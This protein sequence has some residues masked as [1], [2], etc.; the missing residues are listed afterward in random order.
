VSAVNEQLVSRLMRDKER[1]RVAVYAIAGHP[2]TP[3]RVREIAVSALN[4]LREAL[5]PPCGL[6]HQGGSWEAETGA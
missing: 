2:Q 4:D 5:P 1:L 3:D 6:T